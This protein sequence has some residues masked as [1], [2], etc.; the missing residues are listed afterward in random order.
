MVEFY[1]GGA[2]APPSPPTST[3]VVGVVLVGSCSNKDSGPGGQQL[4]FIFIRWRI[5]LNGELS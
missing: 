2:S 5:V 3:P 4:G 1:L